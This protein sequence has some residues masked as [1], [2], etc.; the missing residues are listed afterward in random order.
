MYLTEAPRGISYIFLGIASRADVAVRCTGA[1]T[2]KILADLTS[3]SPDNTETVSGF[4]LESQSTLTLMTLNVEPR[5]KE[6]DPD[7]APFTVNR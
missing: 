1:G 7:L 2:I 5:K 3:T 6:A 4:P